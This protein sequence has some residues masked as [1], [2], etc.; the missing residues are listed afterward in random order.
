MLFCGQFLL[1]YTRSASKALRGMARRDK[2][3]RSLCGML[4]PTCNHLDQ[5]GIG[6]TLAACSR[7]YGKV[8]CIRKELMH[9][10]FHGVFADLIYSISHCDYF[11]IILAL[12]SVL[13]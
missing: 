11:L 10:I 1:E 4:V 5:H 8:L 12:L 9:Y 2:I 6:T 3:L 7:L 13:S